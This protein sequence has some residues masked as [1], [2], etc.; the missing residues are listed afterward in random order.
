MIFRSMMDMGYFFRCIA[1]LLICYCSASTNASTIVIDPGPVGTYLVRSQSNLPDLNGTAL[2]GQLLGLDFVFSGM[3]YVVTPESGPFP[4]YFNIDLTFSSTPD[5]LWPDLDMH[6]SSITDETG[7]VHNGSLTSSSSWDNVSSNYSLGSVTFS[8]I[9]FSFYLPN[10]PGVTIEQ[11]G[12]EIFM[13]PVGHGGFVVGE[14]AAVPI[15][16]A[17]WLFGSALLTLAGIKRRKAAA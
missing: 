5:P 2:E 14:L 3:K 7:A 16:A 10:A 17:A 9:Q 12:W 8:E 13:P 1:V 15:P 11:L 4:L 6:S